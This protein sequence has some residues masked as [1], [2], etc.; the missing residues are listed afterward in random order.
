VTGTSGDVHRA[1]TSVAARLTGDRKAP[2]DEHSRGA[3]VVSSA[4]LFAE[5]QPR[6]RRYILSMVH[7]PTEA[8]DLSQ[9]VFLQAHRKLGSLR[10]PDALA[11]W[12]YRIATHACYDRFRKWSRQPGFDPLDSNGSVSGNAAG[13]DTDEPR[14]DRVIERAEMTACVR[15][16]LEELSDEYRQVILLHDME[17]LTNPEIASMLDVSLDAI[18]I[19]LHR[20]RRKLQAALGANCNFSNDEDGVFVCEPASPRVP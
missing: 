4:D 3:T 14:L 15:G 17:G 16:Y 9:E 8:D 2:R 19:R 5:Y 20:A 1:A 7:D 11:P 6:I 13:A 10:D 12:L 18:K